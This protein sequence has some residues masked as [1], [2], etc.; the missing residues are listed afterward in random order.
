MLPLLFVEKE[1]VSFSRVL[2]PFSEEKEQGE[3]RFQQYNS[4]F[5]N[6]V[7]EDVVVMA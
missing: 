4:F 2:L 5:Y 1:H 6:A 3:V 7:E